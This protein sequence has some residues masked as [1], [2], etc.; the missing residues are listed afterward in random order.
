[1]DES[2][3]TGRFLILTLHSHDVL[4]TP[5]AISYHNM[6]V[7]I[8][9]ITQV[10]LLSIRGF[11]SGIFHRNVLDLSS[12]DELKEIYGLRQRDWMR[13][14]L[15]GRVKSSRFSLIEPCQARGSLWMKRSALLFHHP[16]LLQSWLQLLLLFFF[17]SFFLG[18]VN[19]SPHT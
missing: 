13:E 15:W 14:G 16:E 5:L 19:V 1:M 4:K 12:K 7:Q 10:P 3:T 2:K 6:E 11:C 8:N 17:F 9:N 18:R